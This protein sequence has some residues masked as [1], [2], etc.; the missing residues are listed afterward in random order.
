MSRLKGT[1]A[2]RPAEEKAEK[3][4]RMIDDSTR[5]LEILLDRIDAMSNSFSNDIEVFVENA[6]G[7]LG[8]IPSDATTS[9]VIRQ[10]T[11]AET[12]ISRIRENSMKAVNGIKEMG[13]PLATLLSS[14]KEL[15]SI[16][17]SEGGESA[18][19]VF[20]ERKGTG[21]ELPDL[22]LNLRRKEE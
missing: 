18:E 22:S 9:G 7:F 2:G 4:L 8:N 10:I 15:K 21:V 1:D 5:N 6:R 16:L 19:V 14:L 20:E 12:E 11:K 3:M 17:E 13:G